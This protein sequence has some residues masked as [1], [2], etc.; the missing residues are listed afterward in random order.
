MA[1]PLQDLSSR[2]NPTKGTRLSESEPMPYYIQRRDYTNVV[3]TIDEYE[4][5]K[6]AYMA[7]REHNLRDPDAR[8]YVAK[9]PCKT[10]ANEKQTAHLT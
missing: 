6:E 9:K 1:V 8:H 4:D 10:W 2:L 3:K 5:A 7:A